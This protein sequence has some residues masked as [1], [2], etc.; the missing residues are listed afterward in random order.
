MVIG[1]MKYITEI[2]GKP[3]TTWL[4]LSQFDDL[5]KGYRQ[6]A[7]KQGKKPTATEIHE[8]IWCHLEHQHALRNEHVERERQSAA[9]RQVQYCGTA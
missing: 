3:L 6:R 4:T 5:R 8:T 7:K 2:N 9:L 1:A